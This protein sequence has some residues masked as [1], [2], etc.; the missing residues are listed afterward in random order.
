MNI[1][2]TI[3][4]I[5]RNMY[6][7]QVEFAHLLGISKSALCLYEKGTRIPRL[8]TIK[9]LTDC[10]KKVHIKLSVNDFYKDE[11]K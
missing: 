9:K 10:A 5:R 6:L 1:T 11:N 8:P 2:S 3:R 7:N 4:Q